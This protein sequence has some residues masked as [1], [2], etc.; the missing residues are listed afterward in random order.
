MEGQS[1]REGVSSVC[2]ALGSGSS[3]L[4]AWALVPSSELP[5]GRSAAFLF[6][7]LRG[8]R[9]TSVTALEAL[10]RRPTPETVWAP[11]SFQLLRPHGAFLQGLHAPSASDAP[12]CPRQVTSQGL[13]SSSP[14]ERSRVPSDRHSWALWVFS[15]WAAWKG[16]ECLGVHVR[17]APIKGLCGRDLKD[18]GGCVPGATPSN[19]VT[20]PPAPSR[21]WE[22]VST[23]CHV[24]TPL[25][26]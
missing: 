4:Q 19:T 15:V 16:P 20:H 8:R 5:S 13:I 2:L 14:Q 11:F 12:L 25:P 22:E 10:W 21:A 26:Q 1:G 9:P 3:W 17:P 6:P 23:G 24:C 18:C 7:L